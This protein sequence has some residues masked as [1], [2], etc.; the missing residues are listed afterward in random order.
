MTKNAPLFNRI[1]PCLCAL[2]LLLPGVCQAAVFF[3]EVAWM[4]NSTSANH[5]WIELYNDGSAVDVEGWTLTD[6][7]NLS[8]ALAGTILAESYA[9]LERTSDDSAPG[10]AFFIYTGALHNGGGTLRLETA[11][12]Q[13]VDLVNGGEN[14]EQIGGDNT[15]KETAQYTQKGWI[16][17]AATPGA[18]NKT[19]T[20]VTQT[21]A[22]ETTVDEDEPDQESDTQTTSSKSQ[23]SVETVR[24]ILPDVTLAL[25]ID[26]Q[27]VGYVNQ[28]IPFLSEASG[29]G[30][31]MLDSLQYQWNFGD[32][33]TAQSAEVN[34]AF[35]FPGTYVVT[36]HA[37]F[38]RQKQI[39]RHEITI[40]PVALSLTQN[41]QGDIQL[42]NDSPYEV[43]ISGY[44]IQAT[45]AFVFPQYSIILP[46]Q[47]ITLPRQNIAAAHPVMLA[48]Y[49]T[50]KIQL[51]SLVPIVTERQQLAQATQAALLSSTQTN[52]NQTAETGAT[53][54]ITTLIPALP[55]PI[56]AP[57]SQE[58]EV[59]DTEPA[60]SPV[61][62]YKP[63]QQKPGMEASL[64]TPTRNQRLSY[65]GLALLILLGI[66]S[67]YLTPRRNQGEQN[68]R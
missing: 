15:T 10:A 39:T 18:K 11:Q 60:P 51:A 25:E 40:L 23:S 33:T 56:P 20:T 22:K 38:K 46:N 5:E 63:P 57:A 48:V 12:G 26:A 16:T 53:N 29:I 4:G 42:N 27:R 50:H 41:A 43:D 58:T 37:E 31:T 13:L 47:T 19:A 24:L 32:G 1:A 64:S 30:E 9:V 35:A 44:T 8:V 62:E 34:H 2:F 68:S 59:S 6:G 21:K 45:K 66:F 67:V 14:W 54:R 36:L 49:D 28:T 3:N 65:V 61:A 7:R 55:T 17:A 52:Q